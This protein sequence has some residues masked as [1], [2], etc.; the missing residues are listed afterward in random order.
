MR[1]LSRRALI[2]GLGG[3][4]ASW[5][6]SACSGAGAGST[7][8]SGQGGGK[9]INAFYWGS[10]S[11]AKL[12]NQV[13]DLFAKKNPGMSVKGQFLAFSNYFDKLGT[14]AASGS[15]PDLIQ[16]NPGSLTQYGANGQLLDLSTLNLNL[17]DYQDAALKTGQANG[18]QYGLAFGY[19]YVTVFYN[20]DLLKA[21]NTELP[22]DPAS[23]DDWADFAV[24]LKG[25]LP[26]NTYAMADC[27]SDSNSFES[28]M[29]GRGKTLFTDGGK[30]GYDAGDVTA[31]VEYWTGLRARGA[32]APAADSVTYVQTGA[33][34]DSPLTKGKAAM[35]L[36][37]NVGFQGYQQLNK[38]ALDLAAC[39]TGPAGRCETNH[40]FGW[41]VSASTKASEAVKAFLELWF[42]DPS[43]VQIVGTDRALPASKT[44]L[45]ALDKVADGATKQLLKFSIAHPGIKPLSPPATPPS[46]GSKQDESLRRAAEA[47]VTGSSKP[48]EAAK[49]LVEEVQAALGS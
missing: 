49:K 19:Q 35:T 11:R 16:T 41:S 45:E 9:Q 14:L 39:P 4:M 6:L 15:M 48:S 36:G 5:A 31:W 38:A 20:A 12:T 40:F 1:T 13:F 25:K 24:Q 33:V 21:A 29:V 17:G 32:V 27:S 2:A 37:I 3:G 34:T 42:A 10:D 22:K 46:I 7:T 47:V 18:K 30:L 28:W 43:V 44:Q 26:A 8:G 23:W